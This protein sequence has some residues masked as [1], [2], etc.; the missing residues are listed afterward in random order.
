MASTTTQ[1]GMASLAERPARGPG[2]R[3]YVLASYSAEI[4]KLRKRPAVWIIMAVVLGDLLFFDY[5]INYGTYLQT[6]AGIITTD[7]PIDWGL[8]TTKVSEIARVVVTH[9]AGLGSSLALVLGALVV[10]N[11]YTWGTSKTVFTQAPP[12]LAV[13]GGQLLALALVLLALVLATFAAATIASLVLTAIDGYPIEWPSALD[14]GASL[15]ATYLEAAV[16]AAFGAF[17]GLLFRAPA[18]AIGVG[19]AWGAVVEGVVGLFAFSSPILQSI[20]DWM[21]G[22]NTGS[23]SATFGMPGHPSVSYGGL[24]SG[25]AIKLTLV[26]VAYLIAFLVLGALLVRNRDL[27]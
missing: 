25:D 10:G 13:Y 20:L 2:Y 23:L 7:F 1:Q 24:A 11:E 3:R 4:L 6:K 8:A 22:A 18:P 16:W 14:M 21:P 9:Y 12:R 19:L 15:A 26:L 17:L 27:K 5:F